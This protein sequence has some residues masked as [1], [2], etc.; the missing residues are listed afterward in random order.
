MPYTAAMGIG[1]IEQILFPQV[2]L[3][4]WSQEGAGMAIGNIDN[5]KRYCF[6]R[7]SVAYGTSPPSG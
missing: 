2:L 5:F 6:Q 4:M 3:G 7:D 1:D